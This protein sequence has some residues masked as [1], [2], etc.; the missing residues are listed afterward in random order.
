MKVM[1]LLVMLLMRLQLLVSDSRLKMQFKQAR[2]QFLPSL[3]LLR[4][5]SSSRGR[6]RRHRPRRL[7]RCQ[8]SMCVCV[9][10]SLEGGCGEGGGGGYVGGGQ[11]EEAAV[12]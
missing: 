8:R 5:C 12:E 9:S 6:N 1:L 10:V 3:L 7:P 4:S 2:K 11:L